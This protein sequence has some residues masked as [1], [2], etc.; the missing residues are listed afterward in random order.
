MNTIVSQ[1]KKDQQQARLQRS[2]EKATLLTTLL[3]E[4]Q[5]M[6]FNVKDQTLTDNDVV[7]LIN[8]FINNND[9][10]FSLTK[11][12]KYQ[13]ENEILKSY[14]PPPVEKLSDEILNKII[15]DFIINADSK[16]L[17][18]DVM[19]FLK[20]NYADQYDNKKVID[21]IKLTLN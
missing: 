2:H 7:K 8:K 10:N 4:L 20:T 21:L 18:K 1:I 9:T 3:G 6:S 17:L 5:T 12:S 14:L 16:V 11:D 13:N 15:T 19:S